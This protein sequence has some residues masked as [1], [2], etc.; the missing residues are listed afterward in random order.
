MHY[1]VSLQSANKLFLGKVIDEDVRE[2][3]R[4]KVYMYAIADA[5]C[6]IRY[7][8]EGVGV[9]LFQDSTIT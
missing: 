8:S 9:D 1:F 6:Y 4:S 2:I 3:R 5:M 7:E